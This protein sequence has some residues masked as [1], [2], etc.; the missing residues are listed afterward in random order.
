MLGALAPLLIAGAFFRAAYFAGAD[1]GWLGWAALA[2]RFDAAGWALRALIALGLIGL[3]VA[4]YGLGAKLLRVREM[5]E[6]LR[7]LARRR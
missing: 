5:D 3:G 6:A 2:G 7:L 1:G 4:V